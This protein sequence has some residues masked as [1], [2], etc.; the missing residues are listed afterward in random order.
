MELKRSKERIEELENR[1]GEKSQS[2]SELA[3]KLKNLESELKE[4]SKTSEA[5]KAELSAKDTVIMGLREEVRA[6]QSRVAQLKDQIASAGIEV[7]GLQRQIMGLKKERALASMK[8]AELTAAYDA[9]VS[10]IE[11]MER[12][13]KL[14]SDL[15]SQIQAI[16]LINSELKGKIGD[17]ETDLREEK[18]HAEALRNDLTSKTALL[19]KLREALSESQTKILQLNSD[20]STDQNQIDRLQK[21]VSVLGREKAMA[22]TRMGQLRT[23]YERLVYNIE[24]LK[25]AKMRISEL[26]ARIEK[27]DSAL[28]K[29]RTDLEKSERELGEQKK[30]SEGL[31]DELLNKNAMVAEL[32]KELSHSQ[33]ALRC[34]EDDIAKSEKEAERLEQ[35][36]LDITGEKTRNEVRLAQ[37]KSTYED[38]IAKLNAQIENQEVIIKTFEEKIS[39]TFV[40]HILFDFG[41][42][43]VTPNGKRILDK[44]G[45]SLRNVSARS[46]RIEGHTDNI[47]IQEKFR[48]KYPSNWELS[49]ARAAAVVRHLQEKVGLDPQGLEAVGHSFYEPIASNETEEGRAQNRRVSIIIAPEI[50]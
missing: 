12:S 47:P 45:N 35:Q 44:V 4:K 26:E 23:E 7:E 27:K 24:E 19:T 38:L 34:F 14:M 43:T 16:N 18:R 30:R 15:E 6:S 11:D 39:M 42:A 2:L 46:I 22:E 3:E 40:D 20:L 50:D 25:D 28:A 8:M 9:L 31:Q 37:L 29:L 17:L 5:L 36:L 49:A 32:Q 21:Q 13:K 48:Y 41:K 33:Y 1:I 10:N